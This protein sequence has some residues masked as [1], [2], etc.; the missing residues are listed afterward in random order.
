MTRPRHSS[1][2]RRAI[3]GAALALLSV[4]GAGSAL[5]AGITL[6]RSP[7]PPQAIR[8]GTGVEQI[9]FGISFTSTPVRYEL[10]VRDQA[11]VVVNPVAPVDL[12]GKA[13]P[14]TGAL[15]F[16]PGAGASAGRYRAE[17][18]FFSVEGG[19]TTAETTATAIF[20]VA[21]DL[22]NLTLVKFEDLNGNGVREA[23]EPGV[24]GWRFELKNP[25]NNTSGAVTGSDGSVTFVGVPAGV[26]T[27]TEASQVGWVAI[28]PV[29][30]TV[31]VPAN[32]S[33][34]FAAGNA[35]PAPLTGTIFIDVN[36]NGSRDTG[37]AT[38]GGVAISLTGADGLG[39]AVTAQTTSAATG[40]YEFPGL[41]P[42]RYTV[43]ATVPPGFSPTTATT[44]P[45]IAITSAVPS[46]NHDVGIV[47]GASVTTRGTP[48]ANGVPGLSVSKRGPPGAR[49]GQVVTYTMVVRNTTATT[50]RNVV[51]TDPV[52]ARMTLI[53][54]PAGA[55]VV[56]GAVTWKLGNMAP[57]ASR[58][59]SMRVRLGSN[60][61]LGRY[62]NTVTV[63]ATGLPTQRARTSLIVTGPRRIPRTGAVTG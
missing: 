6:D 23:G 30:G 58:T 24:P 5:G 63:T 36:R 7:S 35:R 54:V 18:D 52:P 16:T 56:N 12:T 29:S 3:T 42:G 17:L 59:L 26:W 48:T 1:F 9:T 25:Q 53:G 2:V 49:R 38:Q 41:L 10:R 45:N 27:V 46:P 61:P 14:F 50:A 20:D 21:P 62:T 51:V 22:G 11:G 57:G 32:G 15:A 47:P 28:T 33:G 8:L 19:T 31:T 60:A 43:T 13:S 40:F 37:E 34:T 55:A 44:L 39:R 4:S